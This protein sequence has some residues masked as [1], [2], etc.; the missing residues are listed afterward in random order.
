MHT[1]RDRQSLTNRG[2]LPTNNKIF[3]MKK[4]CPSLLYKKKM[5]PMN[6]ARN[7]KKQKN[8]NRYPKFSPRCFNRVNLCSKF[9]ANA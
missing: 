2:F 7:L 3:K 9:K 8:F 1:C 6:K 4:K 5:D